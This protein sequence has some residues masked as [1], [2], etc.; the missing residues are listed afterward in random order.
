MRASSAPMGLGLVFSFLVL[1]SVPAQ[2]GSNLLFNASF[3]CPTNPL[4]GWTYDYQ[5]LGNKYYMNNHSYVSFVER[6]GTRKSVAK[7]HG[8]AETLVS[9]GQGVWM[10]SKPVP[11]EFGAKYRLT[12]W[13]RTT[14]PAVRIYVTG[15]KWKPGVKP[16]DDPMMTDMYPNPPMPLYKQGSG[17]L[18]YFGNRKGG[19]SSGVKGTWSM[20]E[21]TFPDDTPS[22]RALKALRQVEF[23]VVHICAVLGSA[24]DI[25]V[26][27]ANLEMIKA[28]N[29][30]KTQ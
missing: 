17:S 24:G 1:M 27:E 25:F 13:A 7:I 23:L 5:W 4:S 10:D 30:N 11:Y 14:G 19:D 3:D 16:H 21:T 2:A 18:L 8:T 26:D 15:Y 9:P 22:D 6:E 12:I 29:L 20:G 28:P